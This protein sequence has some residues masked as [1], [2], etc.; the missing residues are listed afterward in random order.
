MISLGIGCCGGMRELAHSR[1]MRCESK[2]VADDEGDKAGI[3][4]AELTWL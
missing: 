2:S 1:L 4:G 3:D